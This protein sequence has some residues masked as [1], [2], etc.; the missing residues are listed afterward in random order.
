MIFVL[1][2]VMVFLIDLMAKKYVEA[3]LG[4]DE[5]K[6]ILDGK[7]KVR[8]VHNSGMAFGILKKCPKLVE[9][10]TFSV[11]LVSFIHSLF[12]KKSGAAKAGEAIFLGGALSN[13]FDRFHQGYVTDYLHV[14]TKI[15]PL[16]KLFF[17]LADCAILAGGLLSALPQGRKKED[18]DAE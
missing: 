6:E 14:P 11:L 1:I 7:V 9:H 16:Q 12:S 2:A 17:N 13:W 3:N 18:T 5:E 15:K 10:L 8:K 4:D